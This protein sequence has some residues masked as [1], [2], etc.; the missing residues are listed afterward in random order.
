MKKYA[1]I[2]DRNI[3]KALAKELKR[4]G[5]DINDYALSLDTFIIHKEPD[6][7][8]DVDHDSQDLCKLAEQGY[9]I[10]PAS[11]V[12]AHAADLDGAKK[13]EEIPPEGYRLVTDEERLK[14]E[15]PQ[16]TTRF[17]YAHETYGNYWYDS[18]SPKQWGN[19]GVAFAVPLDF[20]FEPDEIEITAVQAAKDLASLQKYRD[21]RVKIVVK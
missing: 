3:A 6:G 16:I 9:I 5:F 8:F 10:L 11:Y 1:I 17:R 2:N 7:V 20:T 19:S 13:P 12:L 21:K 15:H 14:H 18:N 4:C